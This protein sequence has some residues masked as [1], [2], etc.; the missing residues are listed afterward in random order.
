MLQNTDLP[1]ARK[2]VLC[3][4][5]MA[6]HIETLDGPTLSRWRLV[7][8]DSVVELVPGRGALVSRWCVGGEE[9]LY[10][11]ERTLNDP[12]KNVRGGI[13]LLFPVAGRL[14]DGVSRSGRPLSQPQH[15]FART[16]PWVVTEAI[17]DEA[18]AR[19]ECSLTDDATTRAGYPFAFALSYAVSLCDGHLTLEWSVTNR[20]EVPLP[21]QLGLHPYFAV[22]EGEKA[23]AH[24]TTRAT[25]AYDQLTRTEGPYAP[26]R[27]AQGEVDLHLLD[28]GVL[29]TSLS[30]GDR[31]TLHLSWTEPY[32]TL[33]LWTLPERPFICVEPWAGRGG[34]LG[35]ELAPAQTLRAAVDLWVDPPLTR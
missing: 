21:F 13:P 10:L 19:V 22:P 6:T 23:R 8:G 25:Q 3:A 15:G 16:R 18:M 14:P 33:V 4:A 27:F 2:R 17:A 30:R 32:D 7:A 9:L 34:A 24:V 31:P 11:D 20:D 26:P 29:T 28:H 35:L 12:S 5:A 1:S